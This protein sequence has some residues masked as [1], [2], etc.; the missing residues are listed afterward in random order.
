MLVQGYVHYIERWQ[1]QAALAHRVTQFIEKTEHFDDFPALLIML[2]ITN[3]AWFAECGG[4]LTE[5]SGSMQ[6]VLYPDRYHDN[7]NCT[8]HITVPDQKLIKLRCSVLSGRWLAD[9]YR[10]KEQQLVIMR[11]VSFVNC[12]NE[13]Y[14][15]PRVGVKGTQH[16]GR[17]QGG[18]KGLIHPIIAIHC[19]SNGTF[20]WCSRIQ[21]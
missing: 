14:Y 18:I 20:W 6:S 19:T 7:A 13:L 10:F 3:S 16:Q 17:T 21:V 1:K 11:P 4:T 15:S 9:I 12:D 5:P 2:I 8:W